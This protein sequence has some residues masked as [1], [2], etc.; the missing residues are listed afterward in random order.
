LASASD[1]APTQG[2]AD[3]QILLTGVRALE[4]DYFGPA[5]P[6]MQRRWR[7]SWRGQPNLPEL[8]R[9]RVAFEPGDPR[10]WP[11][12]VVHPRA[13][14]DSLCRLDVVGHHCKGRA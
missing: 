9:V 6:D 14:I 4:I 11:D 10:R 12:L 1:I 8:V 7:V 13:T 2:P 3:A 5:R